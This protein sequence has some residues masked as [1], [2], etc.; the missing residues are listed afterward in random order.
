MG[1]RESWGSGRG[2]EAVATH[3][4]T[5]ESLRQ[6]IPEFDQSAGKRLAPL[7]DKI[8][9]FGMIQKGRNARSQDDRMD[10]EPKLVDQA[11]R[12]ELPINAR[13]P[14]SHKSCR[15]PWRIAGMTD[16]TSP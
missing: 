12:D 1:P 15:S 13:P 16:S 10:E 9:P 4:G 11:M 14:T 8:R 3:S 2:V 7:E 6:P 5:F